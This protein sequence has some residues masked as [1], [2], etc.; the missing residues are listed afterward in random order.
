MR[1]RRGVK[2]RVDRVVRRFETSRTSHVIRSEW[3]VKKTRV[4]ENEECP[5][6]VAATFSNVGQLGDAVVALLGNTSRTSEKL[7]HRG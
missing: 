7:A 2:R 6:V 3:D 5:L 1:R 4:E